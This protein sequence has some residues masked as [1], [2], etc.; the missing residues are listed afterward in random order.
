MVGIYRLKREKQYP[1]PHDIDCHVQLLSND[2]SE[3]TIIPAIHHDEAMLASN[4]YTHPEHA[5]F[6]ETDE[7]N[8]CAESKVFKIQCDMRVSLTKGALETDKIH[9]LRF[10]VMQIHGAFEDFD[11]KDELTS[12]TVGSVLELTSETTDRQTYPI[13]NGTDVG[14]KYTGSSDLGTTGMDFALT[15][16]SK[17]ERVAFDI[18][19]FYDALNYYTISD[20]LKK[21]Q[22]GLQWFTLTKQNPQRLIRFNIRSNVKSINPY[23]FLG[24]LIIVPQTGTKYQIPI[25]ADTTAIAHLNVDYR[26]RYLEWNDNFNHERA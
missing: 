23:A 9:N 14:A 5:S 13:Y 22:D 18:D 3:C 4:K 17:V 25:N 10:A 24:H 21:V 26:C 15:T 11:A 16:D 20:K 6:A 1:Q 19:L 12:A 2:V 8:C 7:S